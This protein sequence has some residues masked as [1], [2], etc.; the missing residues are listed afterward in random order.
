MADWRELVDKK[1]G[2]KY[3]YNRKTKKT[4]WTKPSDFVSSPARSVGGQYWSRKDPKTGKTYYI[5]T[6]D[7]KETTWSLPAGAKIVQKPRKSSKA[8]VVARSSALSEKIHVSRTGE[9]DIVEKRG[10]LT[11]HIHI[12]KDGSIDI[13]E[14]FGGSGSPATSSPTVDVA[15][16]LARAK[17]GY[18][19]QAVQ[20]KTSPAAVRAAKVHVDR[21][22]G[23]DIDQGNGHMIH[24]GSDGQLDISARPSANNMALTTTPSKP[25]GLISTSSPEMSQMT[26]YSNSNSNYG[27]ELA[28]YQSRDTQLVVPQARE[29]QL[30]AYLRG[31]GTSPYDSILS[32]ARTLSSE[33]EVLERRCI[34]LDSELN[35]FKTGVKGTLGKVKELLRDLERIEQRS[36]KPSSNSY[37]GGRTSPGRVPLYQT[38][39]RQSYRQQR[40]AAAEEPAKRSSEGSQPH[41]IHISRRGSVTID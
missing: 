26:S 32:E 38:T 30:G 1:T 14:K 41:H 28:L 25:L 21:L 23:I 37:R 35:N 40:E 15:A 27:G 5:N 8:A 2:K 39:N 17:A 6:K 12:G 7:R 10:N 34:E 16:I 31:D 9:I 19:Q 29:M 36:S 11:E 20:R 3:Y 18:P 22:G 24:L 13:D 4:T 33:S